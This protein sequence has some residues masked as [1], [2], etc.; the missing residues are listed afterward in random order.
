P[1]RGSPPRPQAE[2]ARRV[3]F[4]RAPLPRR[5]ARTPHH[6]HPAETSFRARGP[7]RNPADG[8][9]PAE[10][11]RILAPGWLSKA[12]GQ[13]TTSGGSNVSTGRLTSGM[14]SK[15][16]RSPFINTPFQRGDA[17]G[18]GTLTALAVSG[19]RRHHGSRKT[20]KAVEF[21]HAAAVTPLKRGV[22][23]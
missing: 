11:L 2:S 18:K 16:E 12:H 20:A 15:P 13:I 4:R 17:R 3:R 14:A 21:T 22:N 19:Q 7:H 6:S 5:R 9:Q 10:R 8:T 1:A 23:E